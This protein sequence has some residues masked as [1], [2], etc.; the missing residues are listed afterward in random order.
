MDNL[1]LTSVLSMAGLA[2]LFASVL[3]VADKKL[4]VQEDPRI[5]E[6]FEL[7]PHVNCG[8]CGYVSC[9]DF[10]EH[11]AKD[12]E[13]PKKCRVMG[14]EAMHELCRLLGKDEGVR[15][16]QIP[17]VRCAAET[18][19]KKPVAE[20]KGIQTCRASELAFGAGM[21]CEYGCIGFGDCVEVCPFGALYMDK[22]LPRLDQEKCTGCGKCAQACPRAIIILQE[23][24][25]EKLFYVAC[26]SHDGA[27]RVRQ[28]C[29]VGCIAC[30]I[31]EKLSAGELFKVTD[32]LAEADYIKQDDQ[33]A[34]KNVQPKCPTKVIKEL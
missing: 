24:R 17:L 20:Y 2:V 16:P 15:Y 22:G 27:L 31:C 4:K 12:G 9:H 25:H 23:K 34:A 29:A 33:T 18:E 3:A 19:N 30:G 28:I 26:S 5:E 6:I 32:N 8:A 21:E 1:M 14:E 7:L 13:D 11:V 10:A